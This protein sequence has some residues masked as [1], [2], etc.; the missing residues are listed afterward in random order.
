MFSCG[1]N[2]AANQWVSEGARDTGRDGSQ[3]CFGH[4]NGFGIY[5]AMS[6]IERPS[7]C[8]DCIQCS[9]V[10]HLASNLNRVNR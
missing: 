5:M 8:A 7:S 10:C 2:L 1:E 4:V 9:A 6:H 3:A